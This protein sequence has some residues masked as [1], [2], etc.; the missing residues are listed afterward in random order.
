[1][2]HIIV[3]S[4][5]KD[6]QLLKMLTSINFRQAIRKLFYM[7]EN[8]DGE[9]QLYECSLCEYCTKWKRNLPRHE[10]TH[11]YVRPCH[12]GKN[13]FQCHY[14]DYSSV[15][16]QNLKTHLRTHTGER[17]Y[18]CNQ[19]DYSAIDKPRLNRHISDTHWRTSL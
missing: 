9:K 14:C 6:I 11:S 2:P 8:Q 4:L 19:C 13:R 1:M 16:K 15:R 12:D 18:K 7:A 10:A 3:W 17:P 5:F